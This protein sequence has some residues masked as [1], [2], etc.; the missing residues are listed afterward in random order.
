[1]NIGERIK[2]LRTEKGITQSKL[3]NKM[4]ISQ[5]TVV[6]FE[7]ENANPTIETLKKIAAALD[8]TMYDIF[9]LKIDNMSD[10]DIECLKTFQKLNK[11]GKD[12][13]IDFIN[14]L[15]KLDDYNK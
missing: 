15:Y 4:N 11:K 10:Q 9:D 13:A 1:M 6:S 7:S 3:A 2:K 5:A 8:I 14:I 12:K